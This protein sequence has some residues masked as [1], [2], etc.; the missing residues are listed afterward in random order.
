M[1]RVRQHPNTR[2]LFRAA[3]LTVVSA[4][5]SVNEVR[6]AAQGKTAAGEIRNLGRVVRAKGGFFAFFTSGGEQKTV[7]YTF[8]DETSK[9]LRTETDQ[10]P[11]EWTTPK[12]GTLEIRYIPGEKGTSRLA[13]N[14][15][16]VPVVGF[17]VSLLLTAVF[18]S[19][20]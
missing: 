2:W 15:N 9:E 5:F 7:E 19:N 6:Y 20:T 16:L 17:G 3:V 8:K 11:T 14:Q 12:D 4:F 10:T 18:A 1:A 13:E